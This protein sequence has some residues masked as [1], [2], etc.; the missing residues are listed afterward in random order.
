[1]LGSD[2]PVGAS[3]G[4]HTRIP[5]DAVAEAVEGEKIGILDSHEGWMEGSL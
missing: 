2:Q 5:I 1:M 3:I 4:W